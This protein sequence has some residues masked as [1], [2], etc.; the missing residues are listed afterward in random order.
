MEK[1]I[2]DVYSLLR[3]GRGPQQGT[4]PLPSVDTLLPSTTRSEH[5]SSSHPSGVSLACASS[6]YQIVSSSSFQPGRSREDV[7]G[8]GIIST[9][10]AES[11]IKTFIS[12]YWCFPFVILPA[13][14]IAGYRRERP[15]LLLSVLAITSRKYFELHN[16]LELEFR[17]ILSTKVIFEG[18][19]D[20]DLLQGLLVYLAW[21]VP[22]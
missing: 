22:C 2:N 12:D 5:K 6:A 21:Y 1:K 4:T 20:L 19:K 18:A 10:E 14:T 7:I 17:E 8:K 16:S 13:N 11:L 15:I 9:Q 3:T